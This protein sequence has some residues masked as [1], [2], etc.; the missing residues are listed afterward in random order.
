MHE[1]FNKLTK[2]QYFNFRDINCLTIKYLLSHS[3]Y[4][5]QFRNVG[6][7]FLLKYNMINAKNY[8]YFQLYI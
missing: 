8:L 7:I 3:Q 1:P 4:Y 2:S 6:R 5:I